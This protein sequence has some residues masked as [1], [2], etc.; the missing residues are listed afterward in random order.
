MKK[1]YLHNE[2][3]QTGPFDIDDLKTKNINKNTPIWYE[4][5]A[6]WTTAERVDEL[7]DLFMTATP[8]PFVTK[9]TPPPVKKPLQQQTVTTKKKSN[10][11]GKVL[12]S[13]GAVGAILIVAIIIIGNMNKS[14][15]ANPQSYQEKV[16]SIEEVERSQ[17]TNFLSADGT[18]HENFWGNK[19]KVN[20]TITNKATVAAYKD[21]VV[22]VTYYTKTKTVL[23]SKDYTIYE[24]FPPSST[25][26]VELE[27]ENYQNVNSIGW[28]VI[29]ATA[30]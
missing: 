6:D 19:F 8:P 30:N 17:P 2:T 25:K 4:G 12:T 22:R 1:F 9:Q 18:Y 11:L 5:L 14:G 3:E 15:G 24:M 13:I 16:M 23:G 27:I 28:D 21:A 10:T 20:C 26:T 29:R 7:K